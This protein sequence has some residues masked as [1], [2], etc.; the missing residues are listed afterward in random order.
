S[1]SGRSTGADDGRRRSASDLLAP[2]RRFDRRPDRAYC[3]TRIAARAKAVSST[4]NTD[5]IPQF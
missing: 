2:G 3:Q 5:P 4:A 1:S